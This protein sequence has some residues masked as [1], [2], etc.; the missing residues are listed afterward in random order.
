M[1]IDALARWLRC[2]VCADPLEPIE[3][4]TLGC[5]SG[6]RF[7]V[8]KRGYVNLVAGGTKLIGDSPEMLDARDT[9]LGSGLYAPISDAL[10]S[11]A[12]GS[13]ILDAGV[14]T[15]HYLRS[16]LAANPGARGMAMDLSP[17]AVARAVQSSP[18][19]DGLVAD[20]W[21][22]LPIRDAACDIVLDVFAPR[23]LP[24]F[25][26]ILKPAGGLFV[27]VPLADHLAE[28]RAGGRML[29]VPADKAAAI[30]ASAA[31]LF[32]LRERRTIRATI[33]LTATAAAAL[34]AMGPSAHHP[35]PVAGGQTALDAEEHDAPSSATLAVDILHLSRD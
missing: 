24:E 15:G 25:H 19:V 13:S 2:P 30:V 20:T 7:D 11:L 23:N 26:R 21:R 22:P 12:T 6:H 10:I 33:P 34:V 31:P 8:N 28:L 32:T 17:A 18:D 5:A 29:D 27:V 9:V 3:R 4:L 35:R 14:G 1:T 16:V